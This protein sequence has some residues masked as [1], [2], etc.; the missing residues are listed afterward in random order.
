MMFSF[1]H[2]LKSSLSL[3]ISCVILFGSPLSQASDKPASGMIQNS[4]VLIDNDFDIDDMMAIPMI[5]GNKYVAAIIQSEGYTLPEHSAAAI[6]ELVNNIPDRPNQRKI[7][8][9]VGGKQSPSPDYTQWFW[10]D[11]FRTMMNQ[12]NALLPE[13]PK[14]WPTDKEY[15]SKVVNAVANCEKV[16]ILA[17]GSFTS[18]VNYSLAIKD[19]IDRVVIM[20][21]PIGDNSR[22]EGRESFNCSYDLKACQ[23]AM[24]ILKSFDTYF[25]D[26]PKDV[27]GV[28]KNTIT[29]SPNCYTPS[30][31]MVMGGK[32]STGLLDT[33]L[34]GRLKQAL[35]NS[36]N[37]NDKYIKNSDPKKTMPNP[38]FLASGLS[39]CT[40][41][42]TWVPANVAA[43][44]GG[45]AL[46]WDQSAAL[47]FLHPE[48][49]S[50][51]YPPNNPAEGGK[52]YEPNIVNNSYAATAEFLR[53]L[54][55]KSTNQAK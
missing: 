17:I 39:N 16:S 23:T 18:F 38:K 6:N 42:S 29:P 43:G 4:C 40:A 22:S 46:L 41:L 2:T 37:C 8:I 26:I 7:P 10:V 45:G 33:G 25:V 50:K 9:I 12:A 13:P 11:F 30:Y 53:Q 34:S 1:N 54:W 15:V 36:I 32:G 47:F 14:P 27:G 48:Y 55:T 24:G 20:G 35:T 51:Y 44:P 31:E 3:F 21:Q 49:F 19:K 5:I 52:H 28:C